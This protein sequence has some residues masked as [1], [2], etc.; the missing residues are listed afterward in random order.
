M[1]S[2]FLFDAMLTPKIITV[3]YWLT[4]LGVIVSGIGMMTYSGVFSGLLAIL[5]GGVFVRVAFEMIII[6]FK[7]NEYLRKI[8]EKP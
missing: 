2:I 8:A 3:V 1:K 5:I 4:L 7:N 6:A